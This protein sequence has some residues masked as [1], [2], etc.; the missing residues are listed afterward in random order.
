[1][2]STIKKWVKEN[3]ETAVLIGL[4][5]IF[6]FIYSNFYLSIAS[7]TGFPG[8]PL[9]FN[10]PDETA[11][12]FFASTYVK[13]GVLRIFEPLNFIAGNRIQPR[14]T[15]VVGGYLV[16]GSF[17]GL[18]LIYGW[19]AKIAGL[20]A[21]LVLTPIFACLAVFCFHEIIKKIFGRQIAFWS[22]GLLLIH[23]AFWY[24]AARGL[25]PN[26]LFVSFLIF[27]V[28]FL[29]RVGEELPQSGHEK[30]GKKRNYVD[31]ILAG[32]FFGL[33][34]TVRLSEIIWV[35]AAFS[36]LFLIFRKKLKWEQAAIFVI[37]AILTFSPIFAYNQIFYG[38]SLLTAYNLGG[39]GAPAGG[40]GQGVGWLV[41]SARYVFPFGFH[42][43][44]IL[45][46]FSNYFAGMFWWLVVPL[47]FGAVFFI[48]KLIDG[49]LDKK[50]RTYLLFSGGISIFLFAYYGSWLFYDNPAEEV[51][52]GTSY[53]RYWLPIHILSLPFATFAFVKFVEWFRAGE[54]K[55]V[56][57]S[58]GLCCFLLSAGLVFFDKNDGLVK[59]RANTKEYAYIAGEVNRMIEPEA[60]IVVDRADKIFFPEH[61]VIQPLRDDQVYKLIPELAREVPLYYYGVTLPEKDIDYLYAK[62]FNREELEIKKIRDFGAETLYKF[63][64]IE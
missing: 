6:F 16:P 28:Y 33:A 32:L 11:N 42:V 24:Y 1:M 43:K 64:E 38:N 51:S 5:F 10:S 53:V 26:I 4:I 9:K 61:Q 7:E 31:F 23:P 58:L 8:S 35:G 36:V 37:F 55:I 20:K 59:V 25:Y 48:K 22:G 30:N 12:F 18:I 15:A 46:N 2:Y 29:T 63:V 52:V 62:K 50:I 60:I 13:E 57:V 34:M 17:L 19:L 39:E 49:K 45:K 40:G 21:L 56:A 44:N 54:R 47:A 3:R 14:S 41:S 27:S